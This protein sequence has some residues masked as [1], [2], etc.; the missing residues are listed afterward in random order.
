MRILLAVAFCFVGLSLSSTVWASNGQEKQSCQKQQVIKEES[1]ILL[2][3]PLVSKMA[4]EVLVGEMSGSF[5][6]ISESDVILFL[7]EATPETLSDSLFKGCH[8]S[9]NTVDPVSGGK[10]IM[11]IL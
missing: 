2:K 7:N 10:V 5:V 8:P 1:P 11:Q 4:M 6:E 3:A 9:L